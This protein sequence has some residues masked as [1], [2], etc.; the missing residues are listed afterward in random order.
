MKNVAVILAG[1]VGNRF[2]EVLPKQFLKVAGKTIIEHSIDA[3]EQNNSVD[4]ICVV[5]HPLYIDKM[6]EIILM[7]HWHK[8]TKLLRGGDERYMSSLAAINAYKSTSDVGLIFHDAV[9]PLVSQRIIND[10]IKALD[11]H[12][13]IDVAVAATDTIIQVE[14]NAD[15]IER[16]PVRK[17]LKRGQTPQA[18]WLETITKA[19]EIGLKD[20][21]F[22]STDDCGVVAKYMPE[23]K[24]YVV[25]GEEDNMKLTYPKDLFLLDKLFQVRTANIN[26]ELDLSAL[27]NKVLVVF[28]GNSGIGASV[29]EKAQK[30]GAKVFVFSRSLTG[31]DVADRGSVKKALQQ[32]L[33][34]AGKIDYVVNS[35]ALLSKQPILSMS[36]EEIQTIIR[37]NYDG[38][39]NVA[40]ESYEALKHTHGQLLFYT[41]S[42]YTRGRAFY[43]LYSSTKAAVVNFVQAIAQ[44]WEPD[45]I[46]INVINPERTATPMRTKN[47][48]IEPQDTLLDPNKVADYSLR[49]LLSNLSGQ[50]IDVRR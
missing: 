31:T 15:F 38:V 11:S 12:K 10:V 28:G 22:Q 4:E 6:E 17:Y 49:T 42:S 20:P 27:K 44:E 37:T 47:F 30:A 50:V 8:V 16:I 25:N 32:V 23:E 13:A 29:V 19:Y 34:E 7:N 14:Q 35:A 26:E 1:G 2:G 3:F 39:V 21:A 48:G 36:E 5:V 40:L 18:F 45:G 33:Q 9:C 43:S 41:S 24:I 46:R